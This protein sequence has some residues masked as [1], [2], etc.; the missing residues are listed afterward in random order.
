R[1]FLNLSK[2]REFY[3]GHLKWDYEYSIGKL[4]PEVICAIWKKN[5]PYA[6]PFLT[7]YLEQDYLGTQLYFL[8]GT[9]VPDLH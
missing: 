2:W 5:A 7:E 3:P 1:N 9:V 8:K 6:E 4:Q